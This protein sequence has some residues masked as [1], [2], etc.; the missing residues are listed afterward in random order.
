MYKQQPLKMKNYDSS[1]FPKHILETI[2]EYFFNGFVKMSAKFS[3]LGT[4]S[5][6]IAL[7]SIFSRTTWCLCVFYAFFS[8][9][10]FGKSI[11]ARLSHNMVNGVRTTLLI[12]SSRKK[13]VAYV[14]S[15]L[16]SIW[17][18]HVPGFHGWCRYG[19]LLWGSPFHNVSPDCGDHSTVWV[20]VV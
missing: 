8:T 9:Q 19:P 1:R 18:C 3:L 12:P 6:Q 14:C 5:T 7:S 17:H 20:P 10:V 13:K 4:Y 16:G 11:A 2:F 15:F